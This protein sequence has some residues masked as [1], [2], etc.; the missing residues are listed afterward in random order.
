MAS[1]ERAVNP[2]IAKPQRRWLFIVGSLAAWVLSALF[3]FGCTGVDALYSRYAVLQNNWLIVLFK[4]N[5]RFYNAQ[6]SM[7]NILNILDLAIMAL[8]CLLFLALRAA[9]SRPHR[10]WSSIAAALPFF[11][12]ILFLITHTAGR[13][14]L[15]IGALIFSILMLGSNVFGKVSAYLG[16]V[17]STLLFFGGDIGTT[18]FPSSM[19]IAILIGIGYMGWIVW[20]ALIGSK[21]FSI[22]RKM[23]L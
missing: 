2:G 9:L 11:G 13:S 17:A 7:L 15:L 18:I 14:S 21:L 1:G 20:F 6:A 10:V 22:G 4:L 23:N 8:F 19:T 12:I 3:V 16:I 5:V